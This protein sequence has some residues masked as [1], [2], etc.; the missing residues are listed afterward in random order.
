M[1]SFALP[2]AP[3]LLIEADLRPI[4]GTRF[5]PTGFPDLGAATWKM[6]SETE[7][8]LVESA[9]SMANRLERVCWD[10]TAYDLHPFLRGLPYIR[11]L[12][13]DGSHLTS[14][15]EE[16]HRINSPYI[17]EAD[18]SA[19]LQ[20]LKAQ[21]AELEI[22]AV[23]P[24]AVARTLARLD[25]NCLLHGVFLARPEFA[26]GRVRLARALSAFVEATDIR[27]APSGGVKNDHLNAKG[28][29]DKKAD[30]GFG[31]VPFHRDEYVAGRIVA[32]FNVDLAQL[33]SY[34]LPEPV[35]Q[36]LFA[37][38]LFKIRAV[39]THG[40]RFRTACDLDLVDEP[41]VRRPQGY[42]LPTLDALQAALPSLIADARATGALG[43]TPIT[44]VT[45]DF[46]R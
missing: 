44:T 21:L 15:I 1:T 34:A 32:Y 11:V 45:Y 25:V 31:N 16:A 46:G 13:K 20:R 36:L 38:A 41:Q 12:R 17:L 42:E 33:R 23:D 18:K 28:D 10:D 29:G 19:L 14:S 30:K 35:T 5:Q 24:R 7:V 8:C 6:P 26:G 2:A 43:D 37:L 4:Q 39:L 22:A 27:V 40:L 3:R 9:Q